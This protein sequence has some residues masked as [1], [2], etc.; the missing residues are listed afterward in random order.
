[1]RLAC[2][3][4]DLVCAHPQCSTEPGAPV[5]RCMRCLEVGYCSR[6]C[7]AAH[8]AEHK[9]RCVRGTPSFEHTLL[10]AVDMHFVM[11]VCDS[12]M[13]RHGR[14]IL[15]DLDAFIADDE[16]R[17]SASDPALPSASAL[18]VYLDFEDFSPPFHHILT[19]KSNADITFQSTVLV[20]RD[21]SLIY[22]LQIQAIAR[23]SFGRRWGRQMESPCLFRCF[24]AQLP[25]SEQ[26]WSGAMGL[27]PVVCRLAIGNRERAFAE[28]GITY[29][30]AIL[31]CCPLRMELV[32]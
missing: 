18:V 2:R 6:Q 22:L 16:Q 24:W 13:Q 5:R 28:S 15:A 11:L 26:R 8:Y 23:S 1:M 10:R 17:R 14:A 25:A 30:V 29:I 32:L 4:Y 12:Y 27:R 7:Q 20:P 21:R 3:L 9:P 19:T 31:L